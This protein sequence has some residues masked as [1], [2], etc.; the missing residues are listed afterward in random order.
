MTG[1]MKIT[2]QCPDGSFK[3]LYRCRHCRRYVTEGEYENDVCGSCGK[4]GVY[5]EYYHVFR[6]DD[7][8]AKEGKASI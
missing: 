5:A 6:G 7:E 2:F 8:D 4:V 3:A 1:D